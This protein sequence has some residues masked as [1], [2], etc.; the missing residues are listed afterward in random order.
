MSDPPSSGLVPPTFQTPHGKAAV[1]PKQFLEFL[2][3]LIT[4][5]LG[6]DVNA[7][8]DKA[9]WVLMISGLSEQVYGYFPYFTPATRG[10]SN[11]RITLTHVSLEVLDQ[12][13]HKIKSVYHGEEDL[14]KKLFVRL[15][16][17]CVS[18]ESWLEAGD[19]SLPDHSDPSTIYSKATN[20]LVY[21]LCQLLSSPFR[22]E[23]S[24]T[25]QRVLAHGLLWESLDL[26]HDILSGPQD[27]FPLDVQFF[28]VPRLRTAATHG[29]DTP[30]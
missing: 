7:I 28:S 6:D 20:I 21:M 24:A 5:S 16:G 12:A 1:S 2:Y 18:A 14:V 15:L 3:S 22:N 30:V 11:E 19:D 27:P 26:V 23:I 8:H 9:S 13:S 17:L 25:T 10:T 4:Q 29:A